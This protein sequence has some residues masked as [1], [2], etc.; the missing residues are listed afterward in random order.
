MSKTARYCIYALIVAFCIIAIIVGVNAQFFSTKESDE[1]PDINVSNVVSVNEEIDISN[2]FMQLFDNKLP[3][4]KDYPNIEKGDLSKNY[5]YIYSEN[6]QLP[7]GPYTKKLDGKYDIVAYLPVFNI[8]SDVTNSFNN[9]T[10]NYFVKMMNDIVLNGTTNTN[11]TI[12]F[13]ANVNDNILSVA[14]IAKLK[15]GDKPQRIMIQGYNYDLANNKEVK[16]A[17][18]LAKKNVDMATA[19]SKIEKVVKS[20]DNTLYKRELTNPIYS[21]DKVTNFILGR[22]GEL[23]I[24]YAYG[25]QANV[26]LSE[27][28]IVQI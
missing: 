15:E 20:A 18:V 7:N 9:I 10:I 14:I 17:D 8:N 6:P 1:V 22:N 28:D 3:Q 12:S 16:V 27:M 25:N 5:L 26:Y 11:L 24:I 4:F 19:N 23:Y 2:K 21:I 13:A